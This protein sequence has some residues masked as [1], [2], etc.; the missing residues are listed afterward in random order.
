MCV[1]VRMC[2]NAGEVSEAVPV[3]WCCHRRSRHPHSEGTA[4]TSRPRC[5]CD[6]PVPF[7]KDN[8]MWNKCI[9]LTWEKEVVCVRLLTILRVHKVMEELRTV[10]HH[11]FTDGG[12]LPAGQVVPHP[13]THW[14]ATRGTETLGWTCW[15]VMQ[16]VT[17]YQITL[18]SVIWQTSFYP[19]TE[20]IH[21][22]ECSPE[23]ARTTLHPSLSDHAGE[24]SKPWVPQLSSDLL[25][26]LHELLFS[27]E[28]ILSSSDVFGVL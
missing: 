18:H 13:R 11:D 10:D 9:E 20:I 21:D 14:A 6:S 7:L 25:L 27:S 24:L 26:K 22:P 1:I 19:N 4:R 28:G 8:N 3:W 15:G 17:H 23:S 5:S 12:R 16:P 2:K